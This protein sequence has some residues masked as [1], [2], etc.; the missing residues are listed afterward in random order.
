MLGMQE[1][2]DVADVEVIG[3]NRL[4]LPFADATVDFG[5][6]PLP[7][8]ISRSFAAGDTFVTSTPLAPAPAPVKR[9]ALG[10]PAAPPGGDRA[11]AAGAKSQRRRDLTTPDVNQEKLQAAT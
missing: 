11:T 10:P 1:L 3:T 7:V 6:W 8:L 4:R 2:V 5:E 9:F